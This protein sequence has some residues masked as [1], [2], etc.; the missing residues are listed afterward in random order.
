[1]LSVVMLSEVILSVAFS[2][3]NAEF[4]MLTVIKLPVVM[5]S[6]QGNICSDKVHETASFTPDTVNL[7]KLFWSKFTY[8]LGK[9]DSLP[10]FSLILRLIL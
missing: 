10:C 7:I 3:R 4:H 8:S 6:V 5:L 2:H 9:L 1:M